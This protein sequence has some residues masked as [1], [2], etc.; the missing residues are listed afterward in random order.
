[1]TNVCK[2][3]AQLVIIT[4]TGNTSRVM[5]EASGRDYYGTADVCLE[6]WE[7][8]CIKYTLPA[9]GLIE[10]RRAQSH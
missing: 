4:A 3:A 2:P 8:V 1:M 5:S 10:N 9:E 7:F 6:K